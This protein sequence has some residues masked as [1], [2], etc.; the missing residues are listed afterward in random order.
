MVADAQ[1][2]E[3]FHEIST[4]GNVFSVV[5]FQ[6]D[7]GHVVVFIGDL[8]DRMIRMSGADLGELIGHLQALQKLVY[9]RATAVKGWKGTGRVRWP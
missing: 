8:D 7:D 9:D 3:I 1:T 6:R 2:S 4:D 5:A